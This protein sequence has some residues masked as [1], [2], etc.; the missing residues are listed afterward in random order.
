LAAGKLTDSTNGAETDDELSTEVASM[1][2]GTVDELAELVEDMAEHEAPE[3][4]VSGGQSVSW[5]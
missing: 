2:S 5:K 4:M 3:A 1:Y